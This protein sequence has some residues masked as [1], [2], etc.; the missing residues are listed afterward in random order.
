MIA[1]ETLHL[2]V[3]PLLFA[4]R[5]SGGEVNEAHSNRF[6]IIELRRRVAKLERTVEF[7]LEQLKLT[8]VDNAGIDVD[9]EIF[10]LVQKGKTIEAVKRYRE[11]TGL[12]LTE[13]KEYIEKLE[14]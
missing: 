1:V 11:K 7:L 9:P 6:G 12:S 5:G 13:A 2:P 10:D 14:V 4:E 8:Y 3:P